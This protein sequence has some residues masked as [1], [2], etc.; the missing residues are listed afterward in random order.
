MNLSLTTRRK[1]TEVFLTDLGDGTYGLPAHEASM[2]TE[3]RAHLAS[4]HGLDT[5]YL[6]PLAHRPDGVRVHA[7]E[8]RGADDARGDWYDA[9]RLAQLAFA[10]GQPAGLVADR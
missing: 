4:E 3:I 7:L 2:P 1:A 6:G 10:P 8:A 5:V 9:A